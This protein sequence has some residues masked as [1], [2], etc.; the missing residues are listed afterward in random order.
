M[1]VILLDYVKPTDIVDQYLAE[2]RA[3]L[4]VGYQK[5]YFVVS[6]PRNPRTGGVIFSQLKDRGQLEGI[7]AQDPFRIHGIAEYEIIEFTPVKHHVDFSTF[8]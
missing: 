5:N 4:D 6:G 7:L 8:V 1:F 3:Y 2:H